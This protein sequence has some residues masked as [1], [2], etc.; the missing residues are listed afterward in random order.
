MDQAPW[1]SR[2]P[3]RGGPLPALLTALVASKWLLTLRRGQ[4][5]KRLRRQRSP[6]SRAHVTT[7]CAMQNYLGGGWDAKLDAV[8]QGSLL[9]GGMRFRVLEHY[10]GDPDNQHPA[11]WLPL[12]FYGPQAYPFQTPQV[13]S[14]ACPC[15]LLQ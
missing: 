5:I 4:V 14:E 7:A 10:P 12:V 13:C 11:T 8:R 6:R 3:P 9:E 1:L 2:A 15:P